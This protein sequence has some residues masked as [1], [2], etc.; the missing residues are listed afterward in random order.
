M[1]FYK[2]IFLKTIIYF[3]LLEFKKKKLNILRYVYV[4]LLL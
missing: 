3:I 2:L 1:Y 4:Y